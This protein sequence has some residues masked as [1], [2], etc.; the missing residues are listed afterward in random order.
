MVRSFGPNVC[1]I[2]YLSKKQSIR[3]SHLKKHLE[4]CKLRSRVTELVDK[5]RAA[6]TPNDSDLLDMH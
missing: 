6:S 5:I 2:M 3:T 1:I 4:C